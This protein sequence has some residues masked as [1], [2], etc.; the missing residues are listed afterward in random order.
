MSKIS[1]TDSIQSMKALQPQPKSFEFKMCKKVAE[2]TSVINKMFIRSIESDARHKLI[3]NHLENEIKTL[4]LELKNR[5]T[6]LIEKNKKHV[7]DLEKQIQ[8]L[9]KTREEQLMIK[10][11]NSNNNGIDKECRILKD[12]MCQFPSVSITFKNNNN[13]DTETDKNNVTLESVK[14]TNNLLKIK[15]NKLEA[16]IL[17][18]RALNLKLITKLRQIEITKKDSSRVRSKGNSVMRKSSHEQVVRQYFLVEHLLLT[19]MC[20]SI[21]F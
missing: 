3:V 16:K 5:E 19:H 2:L 15:L 11:N 4:N 1:Q 13:Q 17:N 14:H 20:A 12:F 21:Y 9:E 7:D 8:L 18:E 6:E 10:F